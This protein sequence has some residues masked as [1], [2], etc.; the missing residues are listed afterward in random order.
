M[1]D[2][3]LQK[4]NAIA[5][6]PD[7]TY[8]A[9]GHNKA[10]I[11]YNATTMEPLLEMTLQMNVYQLS[12]SHDSTMLAFA[13]TTGSTQPE[14]VQKI[15]LSTMTLMEGYAKSSQSPMVLAWSIDDQTIAAEPPARSSG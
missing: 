6:S 7:G 2:D 10:L 15:N 9:S 3:A 12:F 4:G 14:S 13:Q 8:L 5:I 11:I 1:T